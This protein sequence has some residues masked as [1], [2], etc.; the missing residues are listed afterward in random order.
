MKFKL[1]DDKSFVKESLEMDREDMKKRRVA[2]Y[3]KYAK[4]AED[5][6]V[7]L[8]NLDEWALKAA[9]C[10]G[11]CS[12]DEIKESLKESI[13][14]LNEYRTKKNPTAAP[15]LKGTLKQA[16]DELDVEAENVK[17]LN[18][19]NKSEIEEILD[20][21]LKVAKRMKGEIGAEFPN[22]M[23][24][25]QAGTGKSA[26][27]RQWASKAGVNL[28]EIKA[29]TM[30]PTDFSGIY[31]NVKDGEN[32]AT[33]IGTGMFDALDRPNSVLFID[34]YNRAPRGVRGALLD[35]IQSHWLPDPSAEG[36]KRFMP[37]FLFTIATMNP[38]TGEYQTD[39]LDPA[40]KSRWSL[41]ALGIDKNQFK[42]YL[43]NLYTKR[44]EATEDEEEKL[45]WEGRKALVDTLLS[46]S[47][48]EFDDLAE[49]EKHEDDYL[50]Q[51]LNARSFTRL[52]EL[53]DG[54]K[55]D[56]LRR[57]DKNVSHYK[58]NMAE[59]ILERYVDVEDKANDALKG[60]T[61]S[62]IF[63]KAESMVDKIRRMHPELNI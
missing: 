25:S 38:P 6:A 7:D 30:D 13:T 4:L 51:P 24:I 33:K 39:S 62:N 18:D 37:N 44:A 34:E 28:H 15:V 26:I 41:N 43:M 59:D 60:G 12:V 40:E 23:F 20:D 32:R 17:P 16:A 21:T 50:Y 29:S 57:W 14:A 10:D 46:S 27:V 3:R 35:F 36:G 47:K 19:E 42:K 54:T 1:K 45:E 5:K 63:K 9:S 61:S 8:D 48:F 22:Q 52:M 53:C 2:S 49:E 58:K 31:R 55:D 11:N 56:L